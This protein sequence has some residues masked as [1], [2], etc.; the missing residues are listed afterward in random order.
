MIRL[1]LKNTTRIPSRWSDFTTEHRAIFIELC[2]VMDSFERDLISFQSF[3]FL[4]VAALLGINPDKMRISSDQERERFLENV[5][6]LSEVL[7]FPYQLRENPDG[8]LSCSLTVNMCRNL[9]P[10]VTW[11]NSSV[12]GYRMDVNPSGIVDCTL[13]A[14][15]YADALTLT[16]L[17]SRTRS[18]D[19]LKS[20]VRTLYPEAEPDFVP[21]AERV[22]VYY[23]FR[24]I[25]EWIRALPQYQILFLSAGHRSGTSSPLGVGGAF[26]SLSKAGY[27]T[28]KEIQ[29]L[30]AFTYLGALVQM[31]ADSIRQLASAG[32]KPSEISAKM[33]IP[34]EL[35]IP[36]L[37]KE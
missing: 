25:L 8:S 29:G 13:T 36:F 37:P 21:E 24:G 30:D 18:E 7:T 20:L 19:A 35:V 12:A 27:G 3:K 32:L 17:Y 33:D 10:K 22:A 26:F 2:S 23:N 28:L 9:L 16:D 14:E 1:S 11:G 15:Q 6:R 5:Y 31:S 4:T 34:V